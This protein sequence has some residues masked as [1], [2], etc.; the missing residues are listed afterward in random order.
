MRGVMLGRLSARGRAATAA[1]ARDRGFAGALGC[2]VSRPA[3]YRVIAFSLAW[4]GRLSMARRSTATGLL[5][6]VARSS[7]ST[8]SA[9]AGSCSIHPS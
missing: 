6:A 4:P 3:S 9:L 7:A 5:A 1:A 8:S 2:P